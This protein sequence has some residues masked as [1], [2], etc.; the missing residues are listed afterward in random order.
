MKTR[1]GL[2]KI[3]GI[4]LL[5]K[6]AHITSNCALQFAKRL[7]GAKKAG[8]TGSLDPLATGMLPIC[9][10]EATKFSQYLLESNKCY[11]VSAKLG[12]KTRTGDA[13]GSIILE[14]PIIGITREK[15]E[16]VL[17]QFEGRIQQ[18]P[19]MFSA[20]KIQ[21]K[22]LYELAR[23]GIEIA[24]S[25]RFV[26]IDKL[27]LIDFEEN[28]IR[29]EVHCSKGTYIRTLIED[30][31]ELLGCGAHVSALRRS[32]VL[33]YNETRMY[34]LATLEESCKQFGGDVLMQYLLPVETAVQTLPAIKLSNSA[35]FYLR[36]G[37]PVMVPHS[38]MAGLV[39]LFSDEDDFMGIGEMLDDGRVAPRRLVNVT[40]HS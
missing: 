29:L 17:R 31:G 13:E 23:Q 1:S 7:F 24:R 5:D 20:V 18:V 11:Q 27:C 28:I 26:Q 30:I 35:A 15:I 9:F 25:P 19:P 4:L 14:R 6:P 32:M 38:P 36:T 40:V 37:Q 39:R 3:D 12:V 10:G 22:P 2:K 8:H 16:T 34:T 33:P 21:G